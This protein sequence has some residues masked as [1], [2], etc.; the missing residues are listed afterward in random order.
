MKK[1]TQASSYLDNLFAIPVYLGMAKFIETVLKMMPVWFGIGFLGPVLAEL[2]LRTPLGEFLALN[3][4]ATNIYTAC[5]VFGGLYGV[6]AWRVG[7]WI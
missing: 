6:F 3:T 4:S 7:R 5:M 1:M 2:Y